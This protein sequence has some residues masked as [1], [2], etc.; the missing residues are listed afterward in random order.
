L[1]GEKLCLSEKDIVLG[2]KTNGENSTSL[3]ACIVLA[4]WHVY[5]SKMNSLSPCLYKLLCHL[6]MRISIERNI[7]TRNN[8]KNFEET[9][10]KLEE[11]MC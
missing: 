6:K 7:A 4:K 5:N 1:T 3:N 11:H 2:S 8:M 10:Q 9:W